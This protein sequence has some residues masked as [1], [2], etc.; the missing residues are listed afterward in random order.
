MVRAATV[1]LVRTTGVYAWLLDR[2][3]AA[4]AA[5][6]TLGWGPDNRAMTPT[7]RG[8]R[9]G[10]PVSPST[11]PPAISR[12]MRRAGRRC[13]W[14]DRAVV[15]ADGGVVEFYTD[16]GSVWLAENGL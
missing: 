1:P 5:G 12:R 7:R 10:G 2:E 14:C 8:W 11:S 4:L 15:D 6:G 16:D 9:R 13:R 3:E